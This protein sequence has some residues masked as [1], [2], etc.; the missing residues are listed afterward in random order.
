MSCRTM[1]RVVV[2]VMSAA[3]AGGFIAPEPVAAT[4]F[5]VQIRSQQYNLCDAACN[6]SDPPANLVIW[7]AVQEAPHTVSLNELCRASLEEIQAATGLGISFYQSRTTENCPLA[8]N[9]Q[10]GY[11]NG[12]IVSGTM[13][14]DDGGPFFAQQSGT[15]EVRGW[16]CRRGSTFVGWVVSC[17]AHMYSGSISIAQSQA[18]EYAYWVSM[19]AHSNH[20]MRVLAGD[21]N[22]TPTE[23]PSAFW[24]SSSVYSRPIITLTYPAEGPNKTF[25]YIHVRDP[26]LTATELIGKN[27]AWSYSDHCY[28]WSEY[29]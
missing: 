22:L 26:Q 14:D 9:G 15:P 19:A 7:M 25:D 24:G 29:H 4:P 6:R 18:S 10:R 20:P 1:L 27:C 17:S 5:G 23:R 11:G 2:V 28:L 16:V 21:F 13:Q 8:S 3:V 12:T